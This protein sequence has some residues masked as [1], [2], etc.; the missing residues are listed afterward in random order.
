MPMN[1]PPPGAPPQ[2]EPQ[3][4][5]EGQPNPGEILAK[6]LDVLMSLQESLPPNAPP[7]MAKGVAMAVEGLQMVLG[8]AGPQQSTQ[9]EAMAGG[10]PKA[11]PAGQPT[12][13][14]VVPV[15]G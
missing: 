9:Q 5:P 7:E 13:R 4:S 1:Q 14:G 8:G 10:N 11:I 3:E 6:I 12:G 2:S 15:G